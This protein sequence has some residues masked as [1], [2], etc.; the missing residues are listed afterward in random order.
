[1]TLFTTIRG[2]ITPKSVKASGHGFV[3]GQ[4]MMY[5]HSISVFRSDGSAV[6]TIPGGFEYTG[7]GSLKKPDWHSTRF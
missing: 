4:N 5:S 1:M 2:K 6:V 7:E 3:T